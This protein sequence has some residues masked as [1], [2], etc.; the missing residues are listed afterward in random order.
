M[1][2]QSE[3]GGE[4]INSDEIKA[5]IQ[6][7]D[8]QSGPYGHKRK[9]LL[10]NLFKSINE[11][12]LPGFVE[13]LFYGYEQ[14]MNEDSSFFCPENYESAQRDQRMGDDPSED[15]DND[16]SYTQDV[17]GYDAVTGKEFARE[18]KRKPMRYY[19]PSLIGGLKNPESLK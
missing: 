10:S 6:R 7:L 14:N 8:V 11:M 12:A 13:Y 15:Q 1:I 9:E 19:L 5:I 2:V 16:E 17:L 18:R 3:Q 4:E